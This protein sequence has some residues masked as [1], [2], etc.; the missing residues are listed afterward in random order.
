VDALIAC[1]NNIKNTCIVALPISTFNREIGT[2]T[3][4]HRN[5]YLAGA[6]ITHPRVDPHMQ[7]PG[8]CHP[9][10]R[11]DPSAGR[12]TPRIAAQRDRIG[13]GLCRRTDRTKSDTHRQQQKDPQPMHIHIRKIEKRKVKNL[14]FNLLFSRS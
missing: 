8:R 4:P 3:A 6:G 7:L 9:K 5:A 12:I 13:D 1:I 14:I 2:R 10:P 11:V